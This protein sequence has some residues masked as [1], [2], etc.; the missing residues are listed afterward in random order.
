MACASPRVSTQVDLSLA[1][2]QPLTRDGRNI[3]FSVPPH[4]LERCVSAPRTSL[5]GSDPAPL[6]GSV[7]V[8]SLWDGCVGSAT[9]DR[10]VQSV[11]L[12]VGIDAEG[13]ALEARVLETLGEPSDELA[14]CVAANARRLTW[15]SNANQRPYE[16]RVIAVAYSGDVGATSWRMADA[17]R[18]LSEPRR[19][20]CNC[21]RDYGPMGSVAMQAKFALAKGATRATQVDVSTIGTLGQCVS[22]VIHNEEFAAVGEAI[23]VDYAFHFDPAD[24]A[25]TDAVQ[26][27]ARTLPSDEDDQLVAICHE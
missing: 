5:E 16:K 4:S 21:L 22:E 9:P 23:V 2:A 20:I 25:I 3:A 7:D 6:V 17:V 1:H 24:T 10:A 27:G 26:V 8:S 15:P 13:H 14:A 18:R 19:A 12:L 11:T